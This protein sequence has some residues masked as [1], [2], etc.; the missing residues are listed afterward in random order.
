M[1]IFNR[2]SALSYKESTPIQSRQILIK[3]AGINCRMLLGSG[4]YVAACPSFYNNVREMLQRLR[5]YN[6]LDIALDIKIMLTHTFSRQAHDYMVA[7]LDWKRTTIEIPGLRN[8]WDPSPKIIFSSASDLQYTYPA[9]DGHGSR[10]RHPILFQEAC[11]VLDNITE[12][13]RLAYPPH[14]KSLNEIRGE[15]KSSNHDRYPFQVRYST[16]VPQSSLLLIQIKPKIADVEDILLLEPYHFGKRTPGQECLSGQSAVIAVGPGGSFDLWKNHWRY[17]WEQ[18]NTIMFED[19]TVRNRHSTIFLPPAEVHFQQKYNCIQNNIAPKKGIHLSPTLPSYQAQCRRS[20]V[21]STIEFGLPSITDAGTALSI[22]EEVLTTGQGVE[23]WFQPIINLRTQ[24]AIGYEAL[25]VLVHRNTIIEGMGQFYGFLQEDPNLCVAFE[26]HLFKL[27]ITRFK[28]AIQSGDLNRL[29]GV[30]Q[31]PSIFVNLSPMTLLSEKPARYLEKYKLD[32]HRIVIEI[33]EHS[34][35]SNKKEIGE[36]IKRLRKRSGFERLR[37]ALDDA[38]DGDSIKIL[39][40]IGTFDALAFLKTDTTKKAYLDLLAK[41]RKR[42]IIER[43]E[44]PSHAR[45]ALN[46]GFLLGQGF[47]FG[48]KSPRFASPLINPSFRKK[49][50]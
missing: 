35:Y 50:K 42:T 13:Y 16:T 40:E 15:I 10:K 21:G 37:F 26:M 41:V 29:H 34:R 1:D 32:I 24:L 36:Y 8:D 48:R 18:E 20:L 30:N 31:E 39:G 43:I 38:F 12:L 17:L 19:A 2:L 14:E 49:G 27:A 22:A 46:M 45:E 44:K 4:Q 7:E 33:I 28:K 3:Y 25:S 23:I 6:Q 11:D 5:D 47:L 9:R